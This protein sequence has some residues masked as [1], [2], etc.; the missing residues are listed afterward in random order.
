MNLCRSM[1]K[2]I[3]KNYFPE[4]DKLKLYFDLFLRIAK[5]R[6]IFFKSV[7]EMFS[8]FKENADMRQMFTEN[9]KLAKILTCVPITTVT[10]KSIF[11]TLRRLET[12]L[13]LLSTM[14]QK[15]D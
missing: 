3:Y 8:Y 10:A 12:Y 13:Y 2:M 7:Q 14:G 4:S 6:G 11:S 1:F 9:T 5:R 15:N